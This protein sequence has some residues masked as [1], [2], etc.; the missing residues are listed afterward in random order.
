M[1]VETL[2][3]SRPKSMQERIAT[4]ER[5]VG[6]TP[7]VR[8]EDQ[9]LDLYAKLEYFNFM[10]S[11]K[12]RTAISIIKGAIERGQINQETTVVEASSGNFALSVSALCHFLGLNFTAVIDPG[13]NRVYAKLMRYFAR[14]VVVVNERDENDG[15]LLTKLAKVREIIASSDNVF[16]TNQYE[17]RDNFNAHYYGT[18]Q[19]L[20]D[21]FDHLDYAFIAVA[22]GG[23][24]AGVSA[25][26]KECFPQIKI[27]AVD[28]EGS[29]IFKP[30][31]KVRFIPGMGSG[32]CP[33]LVERALEQSCI[34]EVV[35][36]DEPSTI[37]ACRRMFRDHGLFVGGSSG[38]VYA[39][40]QRYFQ[41]KTFSDKPRVAFLCPD[42][43]AAY[44]DNLYDWQWLANF[45]EKQGPI[46]EK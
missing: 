46:P 21:E 15:F 13:V 18:G 6:R 4:L 1:S 40:I 45:E 39:A 36:V 11:I 14:E 20:C 23:T 19:E 30:E 35:H 8:L 26:L 31:P 3:A 44:A 9:K 7:V 27:V 24:I 37:A 5:L 32:I 28:A 33:P 12:D 2:N 42:R 17:N 25:R 34:D 29:V 38:A 16:W 10:G 22:T 41:D 43:G